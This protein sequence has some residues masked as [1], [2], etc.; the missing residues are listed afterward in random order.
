MLIDKKNKKFIDLFFNK[1]RLFF[2]DDFPWQFFNYENGT[3][4]KNE[5][6]NV[7]ADYLFS[8]CGFFRETLK[9]RDINYINKERQ[10]RLDFTYYHRQ[11]RYIVQELID[12][13]F[14]NPTHHSFK[15]REDN[16]VV[17][18]YDIE[19]F[20]NAKLITH[21]GHTRFQSS[22][23]LRKNLNK[24]FVYVNKE[25]Y[26]DDLF[27]KQMK[28]IKNY[29][30]LFDYW[31]PL[32]N[33]KKENL[34]FDFISPKYDDPTKI[35]IK[36]GTKYHKQTECNVLKLWDYYDVNDID[37]RESILHSTK[38]I[39]YVF[40]SSEQI[41]D[42]LFEKKL[43]IY[44]NSNDDVKLYFKL[45]RNK[46][47]NS[48][49]KIMAKKKHA[50][51]FFDELKHYD[52]DV[53]VVDKKP[54]NISELNENKG[55]AI[56]IDKSILYTIKREIYEFTFFTRKDIKSAETEDGKIS[57]TNCR[58]TGDKRWKIHKEFYS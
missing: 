15:P 22:C 57:I 41:A 18:F 52:F 14:F 9:E 5:N 8:K 33:V 39:D 45:I 40:D 6:I 31:K 58:Y 1:H 42:T 48:S 4:N 11:R 50:Q 43:T 12:D 49:K 34:R 46:L 56:W 28:E 27:T 36:N 20:D 32:K 44:T 23:F 19:T 51:Y 16:S 55:F 7:R 25:Y 37:S 29:S 2:C 21:P 13:N 35:D 26:R 3:I 47:V 30:E 17:N 24:C 53:V 54:K 38:Y 10:K